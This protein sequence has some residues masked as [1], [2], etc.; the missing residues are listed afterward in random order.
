ML[1]VANLI[2]LR[3]LVRNAYRRNEITS[4]E[5]AVL[6]NKLGALGNEALNL[7]EKNTNVIH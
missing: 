6:L 1:T 2:T 3:R 7:R 5:R 4:I